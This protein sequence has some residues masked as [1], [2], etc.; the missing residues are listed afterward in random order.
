LKKVGGEQST[1]TPHTSGGEVLEG[2]FRGSSTIVFWANY[3]LGIERD[4][5]A[6]N[7]LEKR[8]TTVRCVKDRDQGMKTNCTVTLYGDPATGKLIPYESGGGS[9]FDTGTGVIEDY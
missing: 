6:Q 5:M 3:V 2:D 9:N 1:R 7:D 8:I 4:T